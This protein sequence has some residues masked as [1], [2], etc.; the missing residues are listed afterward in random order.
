MY[1]RVKCGC[2][3][4]YKIITSSRS[5][6]IIKSSKSGRW[7]WLNHKQR[8]KRLQVCNSFSW[9]SSVRGGRL[10]IVVGRAVE[11]IHADV[12]GVSLEGPDPHWV[13]LPVLSAFQEVSKALK[14]KSKR[15][16]LKQKKMARECLIHKP[17]SKSCMV[18]VGSFD[19]IIIW[20]NR[21]KHYRVCYYR[22][23]PNFSGIK[24]S[25]LCVGP[26]YATL[27]LIVF[28]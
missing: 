10:M 18:S 7:S 24:V 22:K 25:P 3:R 16:N 21:N 2:P 4:S 5:P 11:E 14:N 28:L 12:S 23:T 1:L 17:F 19:M 6:W 26:H 8:L 20:Y 27:L 15:R 13:K 9:Y